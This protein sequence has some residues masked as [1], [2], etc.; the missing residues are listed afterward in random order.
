MW[1]MLNFELFCSQWINNY[2]K[3]NNIFPFKL[4]VQILTLHLSKFDS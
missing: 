4:G 2:V 3:M 1:L